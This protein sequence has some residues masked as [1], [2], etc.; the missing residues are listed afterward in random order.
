MGSVHKGNNQEEP[1]KYQRMESQKAILGCHH[2]VSMDVSQGDATILKQRE[3]TLGIWA[4]INTRVTLNTPL[5][6]SQCLSGS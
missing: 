1:T 5:L 3:R 2:A 6:N 4:I